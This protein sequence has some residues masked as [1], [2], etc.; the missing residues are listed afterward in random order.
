[1]NCWLLRL[2]NWTWQKFEAQFEG[3]L[4]SDKFPLP[5]PRRFVFAP[6]SVSIIFVSGVSDSDSEKNMKTKT[7][8]VVSV[9][10]RTVFTPTYSYHK[11]CSPPIVAWWPHPPPLRRIPPPSSAATMLG[12]GRRIQTWATWLRSCAAHVGEIAMVGEKIETRE[13][14]RG[15][16]HVPYNFLF[17][18]LCDLHVGLTSILWLGCHV[19]TS[20]T[21][22]TCHVNEK[23]S[24]NH[25][26]SQITPVLIVGW[27]KISGITV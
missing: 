22:S 25:Q 1:M 19:S 16:T 27:I 18:L 4:Y 21:R 17:F 8:K 13:W 23:H 26:E 6:F 24:Q 20:R 3:F 12:R 10:F 11:L 2:E 5:Y 14:R 15:L 9:R 7:I